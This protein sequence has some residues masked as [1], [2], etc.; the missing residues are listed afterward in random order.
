MSRLAVSPRGSELDGVVLLAGP[1]VGI[2]GI[3]REQIAAM[4]PPDQRDDA[5]RRL[6]VAIDCI[7][8][9][10]PIPAELA[11]GLQWVRARWRRCPMK[12]DAT[13]VTST[14]PIRKSSPHG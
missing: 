6:D 5:I 1:S 8:R 9:N 14:P 11:T 3:M 4:T 13:C 10:E 2:L 7:R 12:A